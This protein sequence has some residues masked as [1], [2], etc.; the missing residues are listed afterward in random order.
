MAQGIAASIGI[1]SGDDDP[2][3]ADTLAEVELV[4]F[5]AKPS[6]IVPFGASRLS[7]EVKGPVGFG[8]RLNN[9]SVPKKGNRIVQPQ[10]TAR[11]HLDAVARGATRSL[12]TLTINVDVARCEQE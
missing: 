2:G 9:A 8:V 7:W 11:Y 4:S 3:G 5:T 6:Q 10:S 1:G 12:R